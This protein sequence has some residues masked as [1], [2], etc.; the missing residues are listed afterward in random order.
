M[1][2]MPGGMHQLMKQVNQIQSRVKKIREDFATREFASSSGGGAV[3]VKV[4]GQNTLLDVKISKEV[5]AGGD[6]EMLQDLILTATNE[7]LRQ[8][9]EAT[10]DEMEKATGGLSFP[11]LF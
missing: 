1:K 3:T 6:L 2:G 7:A 9:K 8:A 10:S 4:N 11:G 5:V